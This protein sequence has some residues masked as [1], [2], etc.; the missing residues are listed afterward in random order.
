MKTHLIVVVGAA[1]VGKSTIIK[2]YLAGLENKTVFNSVDKTVELVS[3][4]LKR[5]ER[6]GDDYWEMRDTD[7]RR[8]IENDIEKYAQSQ[9]YNFAFETTGIHFDIAW[10]RSMAKNFDYFDLVVITG[11]KKT[12]W[13]R[14]QKRA[15]E[16]ASYGEWS[17]QWNK[18]YGVN[19]PFLR[20]KINFDN[21]TVYDNSGKTA[22]VVEDLKLKW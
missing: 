17:R 4:C 18:I 14:V 8:D 12:I 20:S 16:H 9:G 2:N 15:Q 6:S 1:G 5:T 13:G 19:L 3:F 21:V 10:L 11:K 7:L 22:R